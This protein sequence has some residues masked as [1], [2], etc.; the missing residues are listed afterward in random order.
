MLSEQHRIFA[1]SNLTLEDMLREIRTA[2]EPLGVR[3]DSETAEMRDADDGSLCKRLLLSNGQHM[4]FRVPSS[5]GRLHYAGDV[6]I[7]H[8]FQH[9]QLVDTTRVTSAE[10]LHRFVRWYVRA[11]HRDAA[12]AAVDALRARLAPEAERWVERA[13]QTMQAS[14]GATEWLTPAQVR[15]ACVESLRHALQQ[16]R[17]G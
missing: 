14:E 12:G 8:G 17:D 16:R 11:P 13:V 5:D 15:Q 3:I 6:Q 10:D 4:A 2:L 9:P 7:T 1:P